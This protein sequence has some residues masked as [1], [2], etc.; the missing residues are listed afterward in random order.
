MSLSKGVFEEQT[1]GSEAISLLICLDTTKKNLMYIAKLFY[2]Y[3]G[4][5][6]EILEKKTLL[7][8]TKQWTSGW[9]AS[10]KNV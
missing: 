8:N 2:S 3:R 9:H 5:L 10:L 4:D 6:P 1:T 7:K